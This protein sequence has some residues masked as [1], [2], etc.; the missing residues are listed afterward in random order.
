MK[1]SIPNNAS[2]HRPDPL[3]EGGQRV[4]GVVSNF[5]LVALNHDTQSCM[6][7]STITAPITLSFTGHDGPFGAS[8]VKRLESAGML[9]GGGQLER[10]RGLDMERAEIGIVE[11]TKEW[12][13]GLIVGGMEV[14][15]IGGTNRMGPTYVAVARFWRRN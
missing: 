10:M 9:E 8:S 6:D 7:P 14:A 15:E 1:L 5:T 11:G 4:A 3:N 12:V 2:F 13:P